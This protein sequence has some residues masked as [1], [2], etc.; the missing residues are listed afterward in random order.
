MWNE[1]ITNYLKSIG[2]K[3]YKSDKCVFGKCK[4]DNKL[5]GLL[6]LYVDVILIIGEDYEIKNIIKKLKNKYTISKKNLLTE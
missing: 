5:I 6:S 2:F 3:Q 1:E 4:K